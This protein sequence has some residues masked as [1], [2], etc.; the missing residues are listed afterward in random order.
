MIKMVL[1]TDNAGKLS[2]LQAMLSGGGIQVLPQAALGVS[3]VVENGASFVENAVLKARNAARQTGLPAI[4]DDSGLEVDAL[5][6]APGIHSARYAGANASDA[7]NLEKLLEELRSVPAN[8]R[9]ARFRCVMVYVRQA[10]DPTPVICEGTWEG[11]ILEAPRGHNGFG[12]DPVFLARG[13][14]RSSAE[15]PAAEKN[16]LSHRGQALRKLTERLTAA[17]S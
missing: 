13:L 11:C 15:L 1:A 3:K 16:R 9:T 7:E 5:S 4:A 17:H 8:R 10:D 14:N 2:E 12:Y 6:G